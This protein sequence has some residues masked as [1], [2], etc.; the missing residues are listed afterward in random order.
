MAIRVRQKL[1]QEQIEYSENREG[2]I[3][4]PQDRPYRRISMRFDIRVDAGAANAPTGRKHGHYL[5][6]LKSIYLVMD[7]VNN[8]FFTD[9]VH[10]YYAD[11]F[12][13]GTFDHANAVTTPAA[14]GSYTYTVF[15]HFDFASVRQT[16]SDFSALLNA[17]ALGSLRLIV[18]WGD[19]GD[20]FETLNGAT[21]NEDDTKATLSYMEVFENRAEGP[22]LNDALANALDIRE[23]LE[24]PNEIDRAYSSF[25]TDETRVDIEP[26]PALILSSLIHIS[27]NLTDG[28]PAPSNT[29]VTHFAFENIRAEGE[30]I[31]QDSWANFWRSLK[32]DYRLAANAPTGFGYVNWVDQRQGGLRNGAID[33]LKIKLLTAAP[34][35][36]KQNAL[37]LLT[38][39]LPNAVPLEARVR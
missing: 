34:A 30:P 36:G 21:I 33:A 23:T 39:F 11:L 27:E 38:K 1:E 2:Y 26:V 15:F 37:T 4:L 13:L 12:E 31:L 16:V 17:P 18:G 14:N 32:T 19:A 9:G 28:N 10:K 25:G 29:A 7:G 22:S 20:I 35:A 3:D 24:T 5:N 8:K 6:A